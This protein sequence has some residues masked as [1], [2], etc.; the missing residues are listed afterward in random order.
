MADRIAQL[1]IPA[2]L[3]EG[4]YAVDALGGNVAKFLSAWP[5]AVVPHEE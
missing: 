3:L 2:Y 5:S 4:G 1:G